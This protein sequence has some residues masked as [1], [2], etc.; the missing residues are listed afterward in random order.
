MNEMAKLF[1]KHSS[2]VP[3]HDDMR[4]TFPAVTPQ[5]TPLQVRPQFVEVLGK[6]VDKINTELDRLKH[7]IRLLS[8]TSCTHS[9]PNLPIG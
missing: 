7:S 8:N 3:S 5:S 4:L 2:F 6:K 1:K 9:N